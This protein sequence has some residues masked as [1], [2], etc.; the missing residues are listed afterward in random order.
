M[1]ILECNVSHYIYTYTSKNKWRP[2]SLS[3]LTPIKSNME[4]THLSSEA[5]KYNSPR[6]RGHLI[7]KF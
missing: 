7:A 2:P 6:A 5:S 1:V 3:E 4:L